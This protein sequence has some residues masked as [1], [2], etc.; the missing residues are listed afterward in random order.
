MAP[1]DSDAVPSSY[2]DESTYGDEYTTNWI[3]AAMKCTGTVSNADLMSEHTRKKANVNVV[4]E[5]KPKY[6]TT[7]P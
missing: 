5:T 4:D 6:R 7:A 3:E 1:D 2:E